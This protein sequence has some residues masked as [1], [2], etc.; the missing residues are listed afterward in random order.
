MNNKTC[1]A[2]GRLESWVREYGDRSQPPFLADLKTVIEA[3]KGQQRAEL[4]TRFAVAIVSECDATT[5]YRWEPD[6]V[7]QFAAE[8]VDA[9]PAIGGE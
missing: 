2:I 8:Y 6:A 7:W 1:E 9:R 3:A 4:V 5:G